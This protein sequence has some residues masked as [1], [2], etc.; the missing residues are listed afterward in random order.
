MEKDDAQTIKMLSSLQAEVK[1]L[2]TDISKIEDTVLRERLRTLE[3]TLAKNH[4]SVYANQR[5]EKLQTEIIEALKTDCENK[6]KC[7][8]KCR[9]VIEANEKA[10]KVSSKD[11]ISDIEQKIIENEQM[12]EKTKGYTCEGCFQNFGKILKREKRAYKEIVLVEQPNVAVNDETLDIPFLINIWLEPLSNE[13]RLRILD[14][15]YHGKK[16][17]SELS[18]DLGLKAGHLVFHLK[19]LNAAKLIAQESS[20]GDYILTDRGLRLIKKML[21]LQNEEKKNPAN[22]QLNE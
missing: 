18:R 5:C 1:S 13:A 3:E 12:I 9:D 21:L 17:F 4:L 22:V 11:A 14:K 10:L 19:K 15:V 7:L 16:S 8:E 20:K 2:R 6:S